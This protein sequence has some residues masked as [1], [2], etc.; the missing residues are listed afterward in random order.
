MVHRRDAFRASKILEEKARSNPKINFVLNS[1]IEKI[2]G[3][4]KVDQV[5]IK[6]VKTGESKS[7][8]VQGVFIFVGI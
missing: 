2:S 6:N 4:N 1:V 5:V 7:I 3:D 8:L